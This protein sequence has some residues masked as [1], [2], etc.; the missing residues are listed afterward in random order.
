MQRVCEQPVSECEA[1]PFSPTSPHT[2]AAT[3]NTRTMEVPACSMM[4]IMS[5]IT[6][7]AV[8]IV[9]VI[10]VSWLTT[11]MTWIDPKINWF[12]QGMLVKHHTDRI[13]V[14]G[15]YKQTESEGTIIAWGQRLFIYL[16]FLRQWYCIGWLD[17]SNIRC[18][19]LQYTFNH[20][21]FVSTFT[22]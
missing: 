22:E 14:Y 18:K 20:T 5:V 19:V 7:A 6:L 12:C 10:L 21:H 15:I 8:C 9:L 13:M 16:N 1:L 4:T 2:N 11:I 17:S 3:I